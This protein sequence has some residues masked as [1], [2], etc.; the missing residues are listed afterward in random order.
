MNRFIVPVGFGLALV[1]DVY[2]DVET[3]IA[4]FASGPA[5]S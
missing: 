5:K 2:D 3:A 4:S 1:F